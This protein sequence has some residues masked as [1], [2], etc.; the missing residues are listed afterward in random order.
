MKY[1]RVG[2]KHR[3]PEDP[4]LLY[5]ELDADGWELRKVDVFEDGRLQYAHEEEAT[6]DTDLAEL[7]IPSL[8][9]LADDP[10]FDPVEITRAEFER[11]WDQRKADRVTGHALDTLAQINRVIQTMFGER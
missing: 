2:W 5:S 11:L 8:A 6:G 1:I 3:H 10:Q 7:P 9:E 4:V